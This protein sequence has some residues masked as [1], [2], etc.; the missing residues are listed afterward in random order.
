MI[1]NENIKQLIKKYH[2]NKLSHIFLI[3]TNDKKQAMNEIV[4]FVKIL[5][6]PQEYNEKCSNCNICHL[7]ETNSLPNFFII[8]PDG[9]AIKKSQ[10]EELKQLFSRKPYISKFNTYIINDAEK[11]NASSANTI[12][13]FIE[14]PVDNTIGFLI[15]NNKENVIS[16]IKSRCE[17]V[18]A[19]YNNQSIECNQELLNL[20]INYLYDAEI[21]KNK[22][23]VVN[24]ILIDKKLDRDQISDFWK[25][26]LDFYLNLLNQ[27]L[28]YESLK[29]LQKM[30][31]KQIIYRINLVTEMLDRINYNVNVNLLL[32]DFI[33]RLENEGL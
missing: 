12:L 25:I 30:D 11:F 19:I 31:A 4:Q 8:Y 3:E 1:Q 18:K 32:D 24:K 28:I 21:V 7:I 6:C 33:I 9:Q 20:A 13:K 14:E 5:N 23:I 2:E 26:I 16:T 29:P 27:K 10:M 22:S 15:T 17:L